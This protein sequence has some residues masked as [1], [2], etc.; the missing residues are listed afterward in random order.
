MH[1]FTTAATPVVQSLVRTGPSVYG[2]GIIHIGQDCMPVI[3]PGKLGKSQIHIKDKRFTM[4]SPE[5]FHLPSPTLFHLKVLSS[6][7]N[8]Q[9]KE[10]LPNCYPSYL[11][12]LAL[13]D[14]ENSGKRIREATAICSKQTP[15]LVHVYSQLEDL[16]L[17]A[18]KKKQKR[19]SN[20][21]CRGKEYK[22]GQDIWKG[23]HTPALSSCLV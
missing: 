8:I 6:Q 7:Q 12:T 22:K 2:C 21:I 20:W 15:G 5:I 1:A 16:L 11:S 17:C 3:T 23:H 14:E 9:G 4:T 10:L 18:K 13:I 19:N